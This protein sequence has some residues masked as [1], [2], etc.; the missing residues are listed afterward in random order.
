MQNKKEISAAGPRYKVLASISFSH[1]LNDTM[2]SLILAVYPIL[3]ADF[4]LSFVQIGL[5]TLSYQITASLLQPVVGI[6]TDKHPKPFSLVFGM[7]CTLAGILML[8][9]AGSYPFLLMAAM[10][11]GMGSSIFHPEAARVSRIASKGRFGLAQS[12]FQVGGNVGASMGPLLAA[13]I[14]IPHSKTAIS[15]FSPAA[16]LA[17]IVL[18][19]VGFWYRKQVPSFRKAQQNIRHESHF[20]RNKI[21]QTI[22]ILLLLVFSK[23]FYLSSLNSYYMFY[24][25]QK[26]QIDM[27]HAQYMLFL[28]LFSVAVGTLIGGPVGDRIGRKR[29]IW[30][31]ILG[32]A[33]FTLMLPY[34]NLFWTAVLTVVIGLILASAFPAILVFAQELI[35]GKFGMISGLFYGF[36]FGMGGLGAAILGNFAD[37][38]GIDTVYDICAFLP[39]LGILAV[40][41][42]NI[43]DNII[44]HKISDVQHND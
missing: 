27:H 39:L 34:A 11:V 43:S 20:S 35:P 33:P 30:F 13:W 32:V 22:I 4:D 3:K 16:F 9:F 31:S 23:N 24:L 18:L 29:V 25:I 6:Y 19:Q 37:R 7:T 1:F 10:M 41:L 17:M 12:I 44:K 21:I 40:F 42:P 38:W 8:A 2:Q 14:V 5:I 26:F 15:W 28:F 36:S